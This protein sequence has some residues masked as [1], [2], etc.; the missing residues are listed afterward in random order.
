MLG[1]GRRVVGCCESFR[2]ASDRDHPDS[3]TAHP[4]EH[5]DSES[6][7][8][9]HYDE[10]VPEDAVIECPPEINDDGQYDIDLPVPEYAHVVNEDEECGEYGQSAL[11][12]DGGGE[13]VG[14]SEGVEHIV[15]EPAE[16][17]VGLEGDG[18]G[19][20]EESQ[21]VQGEML[22]WGREECP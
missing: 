12:H 18:T 20:E 9:V 17:E 14:G 22:V 11:D 7:A 21:G 13:L 10:P 3:Y 2:P 19:D 6:T 1:L 16:E 15:P 5:I 4:C 8:P